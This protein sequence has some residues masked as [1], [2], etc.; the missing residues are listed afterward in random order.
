[1]LAA[2]GHIGTLALLC[3]ANHQQEPE[4]NLTSF[5][6]DDPEESGSKM[7]KRLWEEMIHSYKK[8][9]A[10]ELSFL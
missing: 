6:Q 1:M 5:F 3:S 7:L 2:R 8:D 4:A 10:Y 9:L